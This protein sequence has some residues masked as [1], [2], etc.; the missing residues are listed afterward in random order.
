MRTSAGKGGAPHRHVVHSPENPGQIS[1]HASEQCRQRRPTHEKAGRHRNITLDGVI[2][3]TEG[4]FEP[5]VD[6]SD[7][8]EGV[9]GPNGGTGRAAARPTDI[10]SLS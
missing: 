2:D 7:I 3:A 6:R 9:R 10:R 4:W 5:D 1:D 8:L